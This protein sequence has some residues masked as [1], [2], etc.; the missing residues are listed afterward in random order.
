MRLFIYERRGLVD[1]CMKMVTLKKVRRMRCGSPL[2]RDLWAADFGY[3]FCWSNECGVVSWESNFGCGCVTTRMGLAVFLRKLPLK[4]EHDTL[5]YYFFFDFITWV[6][7][8]INLKFKRDVRNLYVRFIC[9]YLYSP[10]IKRKEET[11]INFELVDIDECCY[12]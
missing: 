12:A 3:G 9:F 6:A 5:S 2:S 11:I 7:C 10:C 4:C 1:W 8:F